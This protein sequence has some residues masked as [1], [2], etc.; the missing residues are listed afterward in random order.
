MHTKVLDC[1]EGV[2]ERFPW[3]KETENTQLDNNLFQSVHGRAHA[4][5]PHG[6]AKMIRLTTLNDD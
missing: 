2:K 6:A 5:P 1:Q 3:T 4:E